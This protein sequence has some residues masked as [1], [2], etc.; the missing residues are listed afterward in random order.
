MILTIYRNINFVNRSSLSCFLF[1]LFQRKFY[2][3]FQ[4]RFYKT[5]GWLFVIVQT[6]RLLYLYLTFQFSL[7]LFLSPYLAINTNDFSQISSSANLIYPAS[8]S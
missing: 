2:S 6:C 4:K 8:I 3:K 7:S 5:G 1:K